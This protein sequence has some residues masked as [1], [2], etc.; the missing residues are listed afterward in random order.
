MRIL[1]LTNKL[2]YPP[3]DGGSIATL[4]MISGLSDIGHEVTCLAL[5]TT[6]H[7]FPVEKIPGILTDKIR[8]IGI[9]C[10]SSIKPARLILNLLFSRKPYIAQRFNNHEFRQRL[11]RLLA[12]EP[13]DLVQLEGPYPGHYLDVIR[14]GSKARVS[15]RAHNVEH[16]I[17]YRKAAHEKVLLKRWYFSNMASRL[18]RFEM[19]VLRQTDCLVAISPLDET[20]FREKGAGQPA[21]TIPTGFSMNSYPSSPL[22]AE[23]SLFF[24]GALDWLP[25]QE[26]LKWFLD[27]VFDPL[28][29]EVPEIRFH[30]AGRN[31]P[32][33][34][35]KLVKKE[36]I[37][38]H[39]EV[40]DARAFMQSYRVMVAPLLT[41]SGIRIKILEAMALGR[42]VVTTSIGIEGIPAE[43]KREVMVADDP[44]L[45]KSQIINLISGNEI[46][47][48]LVAGGKKLIQEN[49]D[50]FGLSTRLTRFFK[51]QV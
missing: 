27:H 22:P 10:D 36:Q 32:E 40:E 20:Y 51:E 45:F 35:E 26:G 41:G 17:W 4:N 19:G 44:Q 33:S 15:F 34:F 18:E 25:N 42:P 7:N 8:F 37:I 28:C 11:T 3:R 29:A 16:R 49:F 9:T 1:V 23:P 2:P 46:A 24:I 12:E 21:I 6:K 31:A 30:V 43:N 50:T 13:F 48:R 14:S 38:Y 5:N 39:G 47:P